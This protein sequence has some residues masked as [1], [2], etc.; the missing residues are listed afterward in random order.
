MTSSSPTSGQTR[1]ALIEALRWHADMGVDWVLEDTPQDRFAETEIQAKAQAQAKAARRAP[2]A[3]QAARQAQAAPSHAPGAPR[4]RSPEPDAPARHMP[5]PVIPGSADVVQSARNLAASATSLEALHEAVQAF[6]GCNLKRTAK[7]TV[8]SDGSPNA[9]LMFVGEAPGRDEDMQGLPFIG[10][11]GQLLNRMLQAIELDRQSVYIANVLYWRP[12]GNRT[13]TPEETE[14]C[15]PFIQRQI[16]LVNP[17]V[18]VF[19]GAASSKALLGTSDG[20]RKLRGRWMPYEL[21]NR[22]IKAIATYHPAY[23]LRQ[24]LEKRLSWKDFLA[25]KQ[26]LS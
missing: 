16:E 8:F 19:L 2:T 15:K 18:L 11:S 21:P 14:T 26:A 7:N 17:D 1:A 6:D 3:P 5:Q 25:I 4:E 13:P 12:P 10:R 23:L 20:I 9:R 24:P 22:K